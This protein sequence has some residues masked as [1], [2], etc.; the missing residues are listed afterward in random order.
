MEDNSNGF[1]EQQPDANS[2]VPKQKFKVKI[3]GFTFTA[4]HFIV[5]GFIIMA[6][7]VYSAVTGVV[8]SKQDDEA[9]SKAQEA[10]EKAAKLAASKSKGNSVDVHD[11]IQK[12]LA[13]QYGTAPEGFEWSYDGSLVAI[14][15]DDNS[16]CE[17]VVYM[18]MRSLSILD[19]STAE[20]YSTNSG[21]ISSYKSY[22]SDVS[23][24]IN[25]YYSNFLRKQFKESLT[26]LEINKVADTAVFS[27]GTEYVT[28][29]VSCLDLTDK[30]FWRKDR[31][32]LWKQLRIYKETEEDN[33]KL[34]QYVYDYIYSK[35]L[36]GTVKKKKHDIEITVTKDNG[37]GW[38]VSGDGEL[39]A[40]LQY[41]NGVDVAKYILDDFDNWYQ[42]TTLEEQLDEIGEKVKKSANRVK[43]KASGNTKAHSKKAGSSK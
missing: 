22:Y 1:Y 21:V 38:L 36:D 14:G 20:R 32:K 27:D 2:V 34:E 23:D 6:I 31:K 33:V 35:Y 28:M 39:D 10:A 3:A 9:N 8:Q 4:V 24:Q 12:Q 5:L 43:K 11:V 30:D 16:T 42:N 18:F 17:D 41:E 29:N 15:N 40:V 13:A 25:N 37:S 19:F 26:S 7:V